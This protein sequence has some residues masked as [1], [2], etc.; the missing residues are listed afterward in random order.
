MI[1]KLLG[2]KV[3]YALAKRAVRFLSARLRK[4]KKKGRKR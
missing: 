1:R 3:K 4:Q 2:Y